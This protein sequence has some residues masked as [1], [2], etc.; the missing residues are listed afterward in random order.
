M[1]FG[2]IVLH[3]R[4]VANVSYLSGS[5]LTWLV[6]K[7]RGNQTKRCDSLGIDVVAVAFRAPLTTVKKA[8]IS[9]PVCQPASDNSP[10]KAMYAEIAI[11]KM[12]VKLYPPHEQYVER[13]VEVRTCALVLYLLPS[14][15]SASGNHSLT[16]RS[17]TSRETFPRF[18]LECH[19]DN[20]PF[21]NFNLSGQLLS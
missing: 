21:L 3:R 14:L 13:V 6:R 9:I 15:S 19:L 16:D 18:M 12:R 20:T 8:V 11:E 1:F 4:S 10:F 7:R 5:L 17:T 2:V